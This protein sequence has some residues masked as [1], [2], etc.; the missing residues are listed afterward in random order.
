MS[1]ALSEI[2]VGV[3]AETVRKH[4]NQIFIDKKIVAYALKSKRLDIIRF[5]QNRRN[6]GVLLTSVSFIIQV[7][8]ATLG[9]YLPCFLSVPLSPRLAFAVGQIMG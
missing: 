1:L 7:G 3:S 2:D 8:V 5:D 9:I 4:V 6:G